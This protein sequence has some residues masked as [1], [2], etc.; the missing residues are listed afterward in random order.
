MKAHV[1]DRV[2][3]RKPIILRAPFSSFPLDKGLSEG[4]LAQSETLRL[5]DRRKLSESQSVALRQPAIY[6][7]FKHDQLFDG[8]KV[9]AASAASMPAPLP[10]PQEVLCL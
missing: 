4:R 5:C 10:E 8:R 6:G 2:A 7:M 3:N 9:Y 1:T